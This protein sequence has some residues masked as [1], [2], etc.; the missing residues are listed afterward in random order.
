[1]TD[2][3][4]MTKRKLPDDVMRCRDEKCPEHGRCLRW[5]D[6]PRYEERHDASRLIVGCDTLRPKWS[7]ATAA[8]DKR[9]AP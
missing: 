2:D 4:G 6:R 5:L 8:C 9:I 7:S 1:M 3:D